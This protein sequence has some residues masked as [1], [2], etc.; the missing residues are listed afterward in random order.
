[1]NKQIRD[2]LEQAG[3]HY[4]ALPN[5]TVY[6][7]FAQLIIQECLDVVSDVLPDTVPE[8]KDGIHPCWHIKKHFGVE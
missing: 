4:V 5:D 8:S 1:M 7:R 6:E 3:V 2:L